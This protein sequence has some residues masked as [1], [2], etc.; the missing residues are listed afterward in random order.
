MLGMDESYMV[1]FYVVVECFGVVR[2]VVVL[3]VFECV[4][5]VIV[6][7]ICIDIMLEFLNVLFLVRWLLLLECW[8]VWLWSKI[9]LNWVF[10]WGCMLFGLV[11]VDL[12]IWEYFLILY[13][14]NNV[15]IFVDLNVG[16]DG[17]I[18]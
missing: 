3:W 7:V 12:W 1:E 17:W 10:D 18:F 14:F 13:V 4:S 16:F 6:V 9:E 8:I 11:L 15:G 5:L 2:M